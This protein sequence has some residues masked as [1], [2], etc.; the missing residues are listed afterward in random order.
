MGARVRQWREARGWSRRELAER[1]GCHLQTILRLES[2]AMK[3]TE[4]W[5]TTIADALGVQPAELFGSTDEIQFA[6][7]V[8]KVPVIPWDWLALR[9]DELRERVSSNMAH[10]YIERQPERSADNLFGLTVADGSMDR[11]AGCGDRIIIDRSDAQLIGGRYY[12][13]Q[14]DGEFLFRQFMTRPDRF[15]ADGSERIAPLL[16]GP[17]VVIIG[18]VITVM[19]DL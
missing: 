9:E 16:A 4:Q 15:D 8:V 12:V 5:Q 18:R 19:R 13:V 17:D 6:S 14:T 11:V 7:A 2:G 10:T 1:A 3:M